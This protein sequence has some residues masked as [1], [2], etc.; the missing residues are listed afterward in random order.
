VTPPRHPFRLTAGRQLATAE[1]E[2]HVADLV[3]LV[4][5]TGARERLHRP[6]FGAG[7][8][9]TTLFEPLEAALGGVVE[10]RARGSLESALGDR[11]EVVDVTV[12]PGGNG[13]ESTLSASV[14]YRLR[15]AGEPA[16]VGV[17]VGG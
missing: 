5:L 9:S 17:R 13:G 14:T 1:L 3:R 2:R 8:G 11:I 16:T 15:P 10:V 4:L 7:L 6:D 12:D